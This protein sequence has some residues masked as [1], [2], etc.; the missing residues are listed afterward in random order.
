LKLLNGNTKLTIKKTSLLFKK[1]QTKL[2]HL[3]IVELNYKNKK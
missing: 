2:K 1:Y 3:K